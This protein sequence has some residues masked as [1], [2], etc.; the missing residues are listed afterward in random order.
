MKTDFKL[1]ESDIERTISD[2]L[3]CDGWRK[4][5]TDPVSRREWGKGFGEKGMGDALFIRYEHPALFVDLKPGQAQV[6][7]CEFKAPGGRLS[8]AQKLWHQV[9]RS[10]GALTWIAGQDFPASIEG[11]IEFYEKS[12]LQ[13]RKPIT[14]NP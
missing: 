13:R 7:W 9:E 6:L 3:A 5:K 12:G 11:F 14:I 2:Y 8:A 10:R 4:L 1:R